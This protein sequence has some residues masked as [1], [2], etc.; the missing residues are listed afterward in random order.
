TERLDLGF[1]LFGQ[2]LFKFAAQPV[3]RYQRLDDVLHILQILEIQ[4]EGAIETIEVFFVLDQTGARE[5]IKLL[6]IGE[7]EILRQRLDQR[8]QFLD[9]NRNA[10]VFQTEEKI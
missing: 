4:A 7:G 1:L 9:R 10:R 3:I 5:E 8:Q 6:G 2:L